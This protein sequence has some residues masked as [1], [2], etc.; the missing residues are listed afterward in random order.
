[1]EPAKDSIHTARD[2]TE[3]H[4]LLNICQSALCARQR[5]TGSCLR[6]GFS[7]AARPPSAPSSFFDMGPST[8]RIS[9]KALHGKNRQKVIEDMRAKIPT[10]ELGIVLLQVMVVH[11]W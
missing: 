3:N 6:M 10:D 7:E 9:R 11:M 8:L 4:N 2:L 1:M 5:W